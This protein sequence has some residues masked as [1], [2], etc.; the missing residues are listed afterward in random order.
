MER[1]FAAAFVCASSLRPCSLTAFRSVNRGGELEKRCA[2]GARLA[3]EG[4]FRRVIMETERYLTSDQLTSLVLLAEKSSGGLLDV[5]ELSE[6]FER[7]GRPIQCVAPPA[8]EPAEAAVEELQVV[9]ARLGAVLES[10]H[11]ERLEPLLKLWGDLELP[12]LAAV[13]AL[14]PLGLSRREAMALLTAHGSIEAGLELPGE[15]EEK[16]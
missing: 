11:L 14:L 10:H 3:P 1:A 2:G 6:R 8:V 7:S 16:I 4:A 15:S 5:E 12:K 9:A 13:L